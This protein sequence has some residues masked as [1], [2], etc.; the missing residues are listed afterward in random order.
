MYPE[1]TLAFSQREFTL[2]KIGLFIGRPLITLGAVLCT[3]QK[4]PPGALWQ[5]GKLRAFMLG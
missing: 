5:T 2:F 3:F 4:L 1:L